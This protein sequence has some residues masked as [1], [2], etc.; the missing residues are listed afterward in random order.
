MVLLHATKQQMQLMIDKMK[1]HAEG[2]DKDSPER[3]TIELKM[4]MLDSIYIKFYE[5]HESVLKDL[6]TKDRKV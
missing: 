1:K 5:I 3:K 4:E 2:C 6:L